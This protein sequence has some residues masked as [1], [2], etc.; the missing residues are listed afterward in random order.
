MSGDGV[1]IIK[2]TFDNTANLPVDLIIQM[3]E[4]NTKEV[5][6]IADTIS[7]IVVGANL[8]ESVDNFEIPENWISLKYLDKLTYVANWLSDQN[9]TIKVVPY[10]SVYKKV[11]P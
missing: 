9:D 4:F 2:I 11:N 1:S 8:G 7:N 5:E 3:A 6:T 10:I